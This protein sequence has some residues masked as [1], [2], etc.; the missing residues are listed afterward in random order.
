MNHGPRENHFRPSIDALFRSAAESHGPRVIGVILSGSLDDGSYGLML[1]K[2]RGGI[3]IVQDPHEA[4]FDSMPRSAIR[5]VDVDLILPVSQI[6]KALVRLTEEPV[7]KSM[8]QKK[9]RAKSNGRHQLASHPDKTN[10]QTDSISTPPA[11][12]TCP[13]CGG[14]LRES[15]NGK[16]AHYRCHVGHMFTSDSLLDGQEDTVEYAMWSSVRALKEKIKL[17]RNMAD[18][19]RRSGLTAVANMYDDHAD[20]AEQNAESILAV[21]LRSPRRDKTGKKRKKRPSRMS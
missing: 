4:L 3:A 8:H 18:R 16:F 12:F 9:R 10:A 11:V 17:Q 1:I 2:Q 13:E 15:D 21:L 6:G 19:S 5:S 7:S 14:A 20:E